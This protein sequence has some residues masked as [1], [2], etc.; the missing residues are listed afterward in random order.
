[1]K[2]KVLLDKHDEPVKKGTTLLTAKPFAYVL[3]SKLQGQRCDF[4]FKRTDVRRCS[5]CR[6]VHYCGQVCQ[7]E[8][9]PEHSA[10]CA[11]F[12]KVAPRI[13]PDCARLM[14]RIIMKLKKGG[15]EEKGQ[16]TSIRYRKFKD[17]MSHYSDLK[18]DAKRMEHFES[19]VA[20]LS[21][22]LG[23][24]NLPNTV[25]LM[26][27]FGRICV[28]SFN[29]LDTDMISLGTGIYLAAT[30]IDHSC[31]PNAVAVFEGTTIY[32]RSTQ[33][34]PSLDWT[35]IRI[36]YIDL[37]SSSH[38]RRK[39]LHANYYFLCDCAHCAD[40]DSE[41][42]FLNSMQC[43]NSGCDGAIPFAQKEDDH[44]KCP[45]CT[46]QVKPSR[47]ADYQE[48]ATFTQEQ[49]ENM[50][51]VAY[52]DVC[53]VVLRKQGDLFHPLNLLRAKT[54]D[55]AFES[56]I[57]LQQWEDAADCGRSLLP[58][59]HHYYGPTH[60]L[61]GILY[62]K[63]AKIQNLT[64][65]SEAFENAKKAES[66]ITITHGRNSSLYREQLLPLMHQLRS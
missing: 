24:N 9:W 21:A 23:Q 54:L 34:M 66:I 25:E 4:C 51:D 37:L 14:G 62:L 65:S 27:I 7:R 2:S 43:S 20:V 58:A 28:N 40:V 50:K 10:E 17:L 52:L 47:I 42:K 11:G 48:A 59:Y 44:L 45:K 35:K 49:L 3:K 5:G 12:K 36:S 1:M 41:S 46:Q 16:I 64:G 22:Y 39:E 32:I 26:G 30:I 18:N 61:V 13:V 19:L 6:F 31:R 55:S 33:D 8:A 53:R 57:E 38:D 60:P 63:L 56:A 15:D 29:I